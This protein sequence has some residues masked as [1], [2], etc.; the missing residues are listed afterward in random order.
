MTTAVHVEWSGEPDTERNLKENDKQRNK[1]CF[2]HVRRIPL[3]AKCNCKKN[4]L[5]R[6]SF[7]HVLPLNAKIHPTHKRKQELS[8]PVYFIHRRLHRPS[9]YRRAPFWA[10]SL[11]CHSMPQQPAALGPIEPR[12][13]SPRWEPFCLPLPCRSTPQGPLPS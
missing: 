3:N 1:S 5:E 6:K 7:N 8:Q 12:Q 2:N 11:P 9:L 10:H 13:A 4:K